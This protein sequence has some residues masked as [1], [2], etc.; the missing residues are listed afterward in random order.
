MVSGT[1][2]AFNGVAMA[3]EKESSSA[4][5]AKTEEKTAPPE[6]EKI[7]DKDA[8]PGDIV[9]LTTDSDKNPVPLTSVEI[10]LPGRDGSLEKLPNILFSAEDGGKE[11]ADKDKNGRVKF[12]LKQI[13]KYVA[14]GQNFYVNVSK[15]GFV[16]VSRL[17]VKY[18]KK[19]PNVRRVILK[20]VGETAKEKKGK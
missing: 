14:D 20:V 5:G 3:A 4:T 1:D 7:E 15:K 6:E 18:S 2:L 13:D 10:I 11:D 9:I 17:V 12:A 16:P 8:E 19:D